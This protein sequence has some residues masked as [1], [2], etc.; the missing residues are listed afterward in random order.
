MNDCLDCGHDT[1]VNAGCNRIRCGRCGSLHV[2]K[3]DGSVRRYLVYTT[4]GH[5]RRKQQESFKREAHR[6]GCVACGYVSGGSPVTAEGD[7][8]VLG[9]LTRAG[10]RGRPLSSRSDPINPPD[11]LDRLGEYNGIS[12]HCSNTRNHRHCSRLQH[13]SKAF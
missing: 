1:F 12:I 4:G 2:Q 7:R 10:F 11:G 6:G 3:P 9:S 8:V 5:K 13:Y